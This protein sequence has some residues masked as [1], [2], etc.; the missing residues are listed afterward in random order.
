MG[1]TASFAPHCL[2]VYDALSRISSSFVYAP[3]SVSGRLSRTKTIVVSFSERRCSSHQTR[4]IRALQ[5]SQDMA[6]CAVDSFL[7]CCYR[8]FGSGLLHTN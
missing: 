2:I 5:K 3:Y 1:P 6:S 8:S 4:W 7:L